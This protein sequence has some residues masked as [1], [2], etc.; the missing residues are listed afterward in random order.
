MVHFRD[1]NVSDDVQTRLK[2]VVD[3]E[4]KDGDD[5]KYKM[6]SNIIHKSHFIKKFECEKLAEIHLKFTVPKE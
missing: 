4:K 5:K 3:D 2:N 6:N 1:L